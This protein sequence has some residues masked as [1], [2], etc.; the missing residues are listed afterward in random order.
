MRAVARAADTNTP[1]VYRRFR[2]RRDIVRALVRRGQQELG[3]IL[4]PCST[5]E[6]AAAAY[7]KYALGRPHEY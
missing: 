7:L 1:A 5:V 3:S 2:N 6:K 4:Q